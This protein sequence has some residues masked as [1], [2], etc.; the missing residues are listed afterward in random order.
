MMAAKIRAPELA[1]PQDHSIDEFPQSVV[2]LTPE[3]KRALAEIETRLEQQ[4]QEW[5]SIVHALEDRLEAAR[6]AAR[7]GAKTRRGTICQ[8]P[9]MP[10][11]RCKT[12]GDRSPGVNRAGFS[13]GRFD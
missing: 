4:H 10:N 8:G 9:A 5:G 11:G 12:H 13:G 1:F 3:Q 2:E 7:C 6:S